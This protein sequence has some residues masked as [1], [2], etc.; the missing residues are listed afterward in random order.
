MRGRVRSRTSAA[1]RGSA[2]VASFAVSTASSA[3]VPP[4]T[5]ARW[6]GGHAEVPIAWILSKIHGSSVASFSSAFVSWNRKLLF[7]EPPPFAMN[8]NL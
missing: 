4:I 3:E 7:A 8:K 5:M 6:Y 2:R 1:S